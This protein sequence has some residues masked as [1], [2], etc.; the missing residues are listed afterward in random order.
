M[1]PSTGEGNDTS[2]PFDRQEEKCHCA[3]TTGIGRAPR[4]SSSV[5]SSS[6]AAWRRRASSIRISSRSWPDSRTRWR[7]PG[8]PSPSTR[9]WPHP[10]PSRAARYTGRE[11][12]ARYLRV[13]E[14]EPGFGFPLEHLAELYF[15]RAAPRRC[16][17][18]LRPAPADGLCVMHF[19]TVEVVG[20][21]AIAT[22]PE[23]AGTRPMAGPPEQSSEDD[24]F[25]ARDLPE[26]TP[27]ARG[28]A[29]A[30]SNRRGTD[31]QIMGSDARALRGEAC[32]E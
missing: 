8:E 13:L 20:W 22:D 30:Q 3:T 7:R 2:P 4:P 12:E 10:G 32:P 11:A 17:T 29:I 26:A 24:D 5:P 27:V 18:C 6:S 1:L 31:Q 21:P 16:A 9:L 25:Q 14:F 28:H 19:H 23:A 15:G